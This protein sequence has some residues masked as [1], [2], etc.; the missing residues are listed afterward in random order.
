VCCNITSKEVSSDK[1]YCLNFPLIKKSVLGWDS[2]AAAQQLRLLFTLFRLIV[3]RA[4]CLHH[5]TYRVNFEFWVY[6]TPIIRGT[7][8]LAQP[9]RNQPGKCVS[10]PAISTRKQYQFDHYFLIFPSDFDAF[11]FPGFPWIL[12]ER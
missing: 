9:A 10:G 11:P 8:V 6:L 12:Y 2:S 3:V 7:E 1:D 4:A 5:V